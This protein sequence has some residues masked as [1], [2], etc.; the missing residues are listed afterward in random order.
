MLWRGVRR[1][2]GLSLA[3]AL[4][5]VAYGAAALSVVPWA[6]GRSRLA[7]LSDWCAARPA[8]GCTVEQRDSEWEARHIGRLRRTARG[9]AIAGTAAAVT[10]TVFAWRRS[11]DR[12]VDVGVSLSRPGATLQ[13]RF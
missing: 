11:R 5:G 12:Q 3:W 4:A 13:L 1:A 7:S 9:L 8:G 10:L 2:H 6:L